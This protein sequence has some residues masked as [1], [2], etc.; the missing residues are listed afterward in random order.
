MTDLAGT[1]KAA[2]PQ[3]QN[4][5]T[6][7]GVWAALNAAIPILFEDGVMILGLPHEDNELA[8]H[9][10]IATTKRL[11]E[12]AL[13]KVV[14]APTSVR[15]IDG[16]SLDDYEIVKRRDAERRRLEEGELVKMR[17]ELAAK[18]N[19]DSVYEQLSRRFAA[20]TQKS[21]PQNRARFYEDAV[22]MIA[23]ARKSMANFDEMGERNFARCIERL[24]Q[25]AEV[26]SALV[27]V[28]IL[29]RSGEL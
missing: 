20:T 21:L 12:V 17:A 4:S 29:Q 28:A 15:V 19:W 16:V 6:G 18:T 14:G 23:E 7:R 10:R 25:Y 13:S 11:M 8:G 27:A 1:W 22:E 9:L 26:P 3:I 24:A 2:L 5:V